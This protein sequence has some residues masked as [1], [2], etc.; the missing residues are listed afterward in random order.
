MKNRFFKIVYWLLAV[1]P[2]VI[3]IIFYNN[4]PDRVP[5]HW[6]AA[7]QVN[8]YA[9]RPVAAFGIPALLLACTIFVNFRMY[10]DPQKENIDRSPQLRFIGRWIIVILANVMQLLTV[11]NAFQT[12]NHA[13]LIFIVI[14]ILFI[15]IG[16]YLPKCKYNYTVGIR[17]PWTL[18]SEENWQKTHRLA[19]FTWV[20]GGILMAGNAFFASRWLFIG[21]MVL[22]VGIPAIYSYLIFV[23]EKK[24]HEK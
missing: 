11:T 8:G 12:F 23:N 22:M 20:L 4:L 17:L 14:G 19:G 15:A 6:N 3:S 9:S 1:F 5:V 10:A 18:A 21:A 24:Y 7:G 2:F 16:N 13:K